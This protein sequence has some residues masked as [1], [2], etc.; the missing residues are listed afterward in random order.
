MIWAIAAGCLA[1]APLPVVA[2]LR[3]RLAVMTV[4]GDSMAPTYRDGD[5]L[6]L[7]LGRRAE[8]GAAIAFRTPPRPYPGG[9]RLDWLVKR[10]AAVS[11]D[12]VPAAVR[13]AVA[14]YDV[15][16]PG[17]LVVLGDGVR[18]QDSRQ[19]GFVA[20]DTVRGSVLR[21]I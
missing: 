3:R 8:R 21:K 1:L 5:R 12:A 9:E 10:V 2:W 19:F 20:V 14:G 7:R 16:P 11:G 4:I 13:A 15:V 6:L 17:Y 18:S